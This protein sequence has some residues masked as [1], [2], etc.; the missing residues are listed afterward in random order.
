QHALHLSA[1]EARDRALLETGE[2]DGGDRLLD[3]LALLAADAAEQASAAPQAHGHHVVDVDRKAA[4]DLGNLRQVGDLARIEPVEID[5][6]GKRLNGADDAF[7]Q[8]RLA[9]AIGTNDRHQRAALYRAIKMMHGRMP[10]V[11][12]R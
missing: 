10:V 12:E 11:A 1:R 9:G 3:R 2:A 5:A 4:V 8:R 6:A 7:E